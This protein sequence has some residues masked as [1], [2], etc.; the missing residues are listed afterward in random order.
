MY[1]QLD[2]CIAEH[3]RQRAGAPPVPALSLTSP[4]SLGTGFSLT[5]SNAGELFL[6]ASVP[7]PVEARC[8]A[9]DAYGRIAETLRK[10]SLAIVHERVFCSLSEAKKNGWIVISMKNDWKRICPFDK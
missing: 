4:R 6:V 8:A 1:H 3:D 7:A 9:A 5:W 2:T 10:H